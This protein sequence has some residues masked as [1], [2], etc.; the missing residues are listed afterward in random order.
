MVDKLITVDYSDNKVR[1][2]SMYDLLMKPLEDYLTEGDG[3]NAL[4]VYEEE[5]YPEVRMVD[6]MTVNFIKIISTAFGRSKFATAYRIVER[7][8]NDNPSKFIYRFRSRHPLYVNGSSRYQNICLVSGM[9]HL[10]I[11]ILPY[12][13][14][15]NVI[16][17][18]DFDDVE[19]YLD[20]LRAENKDLI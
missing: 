16:E 14:G 20:R 18:S 6:G 12:F 19:K 8:N 9:V 10:G 5:H 3:I 7:I 15:E 1:S 4:P 13:D 11:P 17:D 2:F